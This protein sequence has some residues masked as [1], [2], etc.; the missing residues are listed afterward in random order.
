MEFQSVVNRRKMIR[1]FK[2]DP[3]PKEKLDRIIE[4][5]FKGPSAGFSQGI[6]ML[7]LDTEESR[8]RF[9]SMYG[10]K[11]ERTGFTNKWP[12]LEDAP[13]IIIMLSHKDTYLTRYAEP[14]KG[15]TDKD[16]ARWPVPFWDID[17]GMAGLLVLLTVVD[18]ELGAV[19][20]GVPD[21]AK[22]KEMFGVPEAYNAVGAISIGYPEAND[23]QSPSLK[24][25]RRD[26]SKIVHYNQF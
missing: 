3:I 26:L 13:V 2:S 11:D 17:T 9:Y 8:E 6:E 22:F 19:F 20:T 15:W 25:G 18:E 21:Q 16:E 1:S 14:D 7:V 4:N 23:P 10:S 5:A 24:R 12:T